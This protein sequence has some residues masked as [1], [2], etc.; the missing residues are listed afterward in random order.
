MDEKG[1]GVGK[2]Y[3]SQ[4]G[5]TKALVPRILPLSGSSDAFDP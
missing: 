3:S 2:M 5:Y 1:K 4:G